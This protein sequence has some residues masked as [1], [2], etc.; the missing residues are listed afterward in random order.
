MPKPLF[1]KKTIYYSNNIFEIL[2]FLGPHKQ[3]FRLIH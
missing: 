3:F 2:N 1:F